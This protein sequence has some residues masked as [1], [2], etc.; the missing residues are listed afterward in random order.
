M[1]AVADVEDDE[2]QDDANV[3]LPVVLVEALVVA[4]VD[5][6]VAASV[7]VVVALYLRLRTIFLTHLQLKYYI[8]I[9]KPY[10]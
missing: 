10:L 6:E 8:L 2:R 9:I 5:L 3:V 7:L 1:H 4:R